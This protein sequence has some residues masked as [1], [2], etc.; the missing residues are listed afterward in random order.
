MPDRA[1]SSGICA[2]VPSKCSHPLQW[3]G[4]PAR[5]RAQSSIILRMAA[6][7]SSTRD[8]A[9]HLRC[10]FQ[11]RQPRT[12]QPSGGAKRWTRGIDPDGVRQRGPTCGSSSCRTGSAGSTL[13]KG[14][15]IPVTSFAEADPASQKPGAK[16]PNAWFGRDESNP[17]MFFCRGPRAA[18]D[19]RPQRQGRADDRRPL[20]IPDHR[21]E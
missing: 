14:A 1:C 10:S 7:S 11:R 5:R 4:K 21:P 20:W 16:V 8:G 12:A 3:R 13:G 19:K 15:F 6:S 2:F 17:L 18:V 9:C